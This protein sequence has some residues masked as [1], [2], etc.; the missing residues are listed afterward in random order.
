MLAAG[1]TERA[2]PDP[3]RALVTDAQ[4]R[5]LLRARDAFDLGPRVRGIAL[6]L[7]D[8]AGGSE[9]V[10]IARGTRR[11][12]AGSWPA[13]ATGA[14]SCSPTSR[15]TAA[16]AESAALAL[17]DRD[18]RVIAAVAGHTHRNRIRRRGRLWL[19][20]TASLAD[21]PAQARA[22]RLVRTR[23]GGL[24]LETWMV[25]HGDGPGGLARTARELA[26]LDAQGGRP[27]GYAGS[28]ADR[29]ARLAIR[30]R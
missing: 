3:A 22:F 26:F 17:L 30:D 24:A 11:R 5:R 12:C 2:A 29:N 1:T 7:V 23:D 14:W 4:A 10:V 15:W 6:D 13:R 9:G 18:P 27:G 8:R 28:R 16:P 25:D 21:F 19:I 20:R